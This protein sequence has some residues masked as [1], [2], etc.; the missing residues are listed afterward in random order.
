M[1]RDD[2]GGSER[3]RRMRL[4]EELELLLEKVSP[5]QSVEWQEIVLGAQRRPTIGQG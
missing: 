3:D 1:L 5:A 4:R 2:A